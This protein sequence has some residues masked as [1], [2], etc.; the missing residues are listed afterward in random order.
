MGAALR[1]TVGTK[2]GAQIACR[3]CRSSR[4]IVREAES[5][6]LRMPAGTVIQTC[7]DCGLS[8]REPLPIGPAAPVAY[9]A[10]YYHDYQMV[11]RDA[12]PRLVSALS[13]LEGITGPG[14][15]LEIGCG[16]GTFLAQA[17]ER[18][19]EVHGIE[20][21]PWAAAQAR[22]ASQA[23]ILI[24]QGEA[25]PFR[26]GAFDAVVSHHVFEHLIDP[27]QALRESHRVCRPGGRLLLIL[28]NEL[29]HLFF[30]WALRAQH[31]LPVGHG[32][33]ANLRRW[34]AYQT[35]ESPRH[36][37]HLFFFHPRVLRRSAEATGWHPLRLSTFRTHRDTRSGY[38]LGS[39]VK[40][41]LYAVEAWMGR[42]PEMILLAEGR[43]VPP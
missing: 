5:R 10:D 34:L 3:L 15:L 1:T 14:R 22:L 27:I 16:L 7:A 21:S 17:Q 41:G 43:K 9:G 19:W 40:A 23:P 18:G 8:V 26:T 28:P 13:L 38:L 37:S 30:R 4:W 12:P 6:L 35:A 11:G 36:S 39:L 25:L 33:L 20:V 32:P 24:A 31:G 42:G 29:Q 2:A